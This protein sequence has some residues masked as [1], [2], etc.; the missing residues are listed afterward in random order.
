M[1]DRL[2]HWLRRLWQE[3]LPPN[4]RD[5]YLFALCCV[6]ITVIVRS[7]FGIFT[8]NVALFIIYLPAVLISSL[9]SGA[10]P[11]S[12]AVVLGAIAG[13]LGFIWPSLTPTSAKVTQS[14]GLAA[15][16]ICGVLTIWIADGYRRAIQRFRAEQAERHILV[17]E[18]QHRSRNSLMAVQAIVSQV[19]RANKSEAQAINSRIQALAATND[20]LAVSSTQTADIRDVLQLELKAYGEGR[21]AVNGEA[22]LLEPQLARA[23]ALVFHELAT[24]AAKHG[25]LS[26]PEGRLLVKWAIRA[27][28]VQIDWIESGGPQVAPTREAGF[29]TRLLKHALNQ[30]DGKVEID[31][32]PDGVTS[33]ISF[34]LP[35]AA[36]A[37][38]A[39]RAALSAPFDTVSQPRNGL[40]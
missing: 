10:G 8:G 13:C 37:Q 39:K 1:L 7:V 30:F 27:S 18:L 35:E 2:L 29:G 28:R 3:G 14:V 16:L 33:E 12:V 26:R 40:P 17:R 20:L 31:F 21:I 4:S 19:L 9:V 34:A 32:R 5:A 22:V 36:L 15:Y 25:A 24:N 38:T 6:A 23:L 11:G